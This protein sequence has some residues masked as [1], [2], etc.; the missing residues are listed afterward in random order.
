MLLITDNTTHVGGAPR[1]LGPYRIAHALE[2]A[3]IH[4]V[5]LDHFFKFDDFFELL[6][7][8]LTPDFIAVGISTTF[9]TPPAHHI[10][11]VKFQRRRA[12]LNN[13]TDMGI[14]DPDIEAL[15]AW[16]GRLKDVIARKAPMAKIV[17]G[18]A[19]AWMFLHHAQ[20]EVKNIDYV[21]LGAMD[22]VFPQVINDL[23]TRG[24]PHWV[25]RRG[26]KVID[27][28]ST[29]KQPKLCPKHG[30]FAHWNIYPGEA[31]PIEIARGCAFNCKFCHYDKKEGIRKSADDLRAEFIDNYEQNGTQFYHFADDCFN[32]SRAKVEEVCSLIKSLP[33]K[34]EWVSYARFDVAVKFPETARLMVESG[35]KGLY[36]GIESLDYD[37]ARKA[38][39]GTHPDK[40]KAF[41]KGFYRDFG[42]QC[43]I[44]GSFIA[45]LPGE[46]RASWL[47]EVD[48][49]MEN[50]CLHFANV[51]SL[52]LAPYQ[53]DLDG[54]V[55]DYADY[56]RNPE[57][58][59]FE[60][61]SFNPTY[62]KHA[63]MDLHEAEELSQI[64]VERWQKLNQ[65]ITGLA[66]DIWIYPHLR[67]LGLDADSVRQVFFSE[68]VAI[69][70]RLVGRLDIE[71]RKRWRRYHEGIWNH[72][73]QAP[74]SA[75]V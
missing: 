54:K 68:D 38:G 19:K 74:V 31:L 8:M 62:W 36:W 65:G 44:T 43:L 63:T 47:R 9:L 18:G 73:R 61:V 25:E 1:Y 52:G 55:T 67:S 45:G 20:K 32:D 22:L 27:L 75:S 59:G 13:Y 66:N 2:Q 15:N 24:E 57:K 50:R 49:L 33:F 10:N 12:R 6:E 48:W 56:S 7:S 53:A 40:I 29:Y 64:F 41:L 3:G 58:Y 23:S 11:V 16:F 28:L 26:R 17:V 5:V 72:V 30:W 37:V 21:A 34:I 51:G 70:E 35:A 60:Q 39:K 69:Q 42:D 71:R 46:T 4:T 14:I